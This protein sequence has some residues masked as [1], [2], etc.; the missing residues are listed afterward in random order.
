MVKTDN[1]NCDRLCLFDSLEYLNKF[2]DISTHC[3]MSGKVGFSIYWPVKSL[4]AKAN[5]PHEF[6]QSIYL[7]PPYFFFKSK[8]DFFFYCRCTCQQ[9]LTSPLDN[10][11][12]ISTWYTSVSGIRQVNGHK[13]FPLRLEFLNHTYRVSVSDV[14]ARD[15]LETHHNR[16]QDQIIGIPSALLLL[17]GLKIP[18]IWSIFS[19][20]ILFFC[21]FPETIFNLIKNILDPLQILWFSTNHP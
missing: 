19:G 1:V 2:V 14:A 11:K 10:K 20:N 17:E 9:V 5:Q 18:L 13:R 8:H 4:S 21:L 7:K 12:S 15:T 6:I 16:F 3:A